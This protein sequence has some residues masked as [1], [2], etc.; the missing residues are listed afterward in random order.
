MI[1]GL[2]NE[3]V[4]VDHIRQRVSLVVGI[5][6]CSKPLPL[7]TH[8]DIQTVSTVSVSLNTVLTH[9]LPAI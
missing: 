9:S 4:V 3:T 5:E 1:Q 2:Q 7:Q 8:N 6:C